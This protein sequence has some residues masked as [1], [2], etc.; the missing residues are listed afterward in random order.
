MKR[1]SMVVDNVGTY[2]H[3]SR[4]HLRPRPTSHKINPTTSTITMMAVQK[5]ALKI[6]PITWHDLKVIAIA[7]IQSPSKEYFFMSSFFYSYAKPLPKGERSP[8]AVV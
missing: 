3:G 2:H 8:P 5:P 4:T 6:S 7:N 1:N